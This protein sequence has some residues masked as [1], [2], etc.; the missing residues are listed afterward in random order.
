MAPN[1]K[2]KAK[3]KRE[4]R[5]VEDSRNSSMETSPTMVSQL[6]HFNSLIL[7]SQRLAVV[8]RQ[9]NTQQ[10]LERWNVA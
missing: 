2:D 4:A 7:N 9:R 3:A 5:T 8:A 6:D 10:T 1:K